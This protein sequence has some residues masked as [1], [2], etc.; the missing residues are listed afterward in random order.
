MSETEFDNQVS[1]KSEPVPEKLL[2]A[3]EELFC[4]K[5]FD[6]T[7]VR[8]LTKAA[9]CNVAAVNYHFG[10]KDGLY[11]EMFRRQMR[12][13]FQRHKELIDT[14]ADNPDATLEDLVRGAITEP[15][16]AIENKEKSAAVMKLLVREVLNQHVHKD[17]I[18]G[19]WKHEFLPLFCDAMMRF[20]PGLDSETARLCMFTLDA[21][22][23]HPI[24]FY[25]IYLEMVPGINAE[26]IVEH[27]VK[28]ASAGIRAYSKE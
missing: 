11:V 10:G 25:E 20:C 23:V 26:G 4:E 27:I 7:S 22:V 1:A 6:G 2:D 18:I 12:R 15:L 13:L 17:E 24:L 8:D 14:L 21:L 16:K 19:D 5:G 28:F 9:G 3:A